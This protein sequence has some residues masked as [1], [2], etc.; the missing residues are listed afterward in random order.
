VA[1]SHHDATHNK[2]GIKHHVLGRNFHAVSRRAA[3]LSPALA[4]LPFEQTT[5][6]HAFRREQLLTVAT[7]RR[8]RFHAYDLGA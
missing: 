7:A 6:R 3:P 8:A 1:V 5:H 2:L 4:S